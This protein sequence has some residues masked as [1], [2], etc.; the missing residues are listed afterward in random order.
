[1]RG[2]VLALSLDRQFGMSLGGV[3]SR[4]RKAR[5]DRDRRLGERS[6]LEG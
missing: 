6:R 2:G 3:R 4:G 5:G 1:M